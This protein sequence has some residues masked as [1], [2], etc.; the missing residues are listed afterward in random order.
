MSSK[1][2]N[3]EEE[4]EQLQPGGCRPPAQG[5]ACSGADEELL[6]T[7]GAWGFTEGRGIGALP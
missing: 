2:A 5:R 6:S 1:L 3:R 7:N 4:E